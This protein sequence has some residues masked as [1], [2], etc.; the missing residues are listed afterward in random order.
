MSDPKA[1]NA[2]ANKP[3][4]LVIDNPRPDERVCWN[5]D[6]MRWAVG[7]G[8]GVW[9]LAPENNAEG[10]LSRIPSRRWTCGHF[11]AK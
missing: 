1:N 3:K 9:C 8:S 5:C 10:M 4:Q 6:H 7:T 11:K 2:R